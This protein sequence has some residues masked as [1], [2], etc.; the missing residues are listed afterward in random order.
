MRKI[1]PILLLIV[2]LVP[3]ASWADSGTFYPS[4]TGDDG[5]A[6]TSSGCSSF[7]TSSFSIHGYGR[8]AFIRFVS[9]TIPQG[10]SIT[11]AYITFEAAVPDSSD[12][13][14]TFDFQAADDS[15]APT[16]CSELTGMTMTGSG[17][18]CEDT[19]NWVANSEYDSC[20]ISTPLQAV[21]NRGSWSSGNSVTVRMEHVDHGGMR[22]WETVDYGDTKP[23]LYV[24]WGAASSFSLEVGDTA[25]ANIGEIGDTAIANIGQLGDTTP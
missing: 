2:L 21:I 20:D 10:S 6:S 8:W 14:D 9:V 11:T 3:Y 18:I 16:N 15:V 7:S 17:V 1:L 12:T 19:D 24:E 5:Q 22:Y 13:D 23:A 25:G 4:A